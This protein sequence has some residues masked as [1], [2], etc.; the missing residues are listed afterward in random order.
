MLSG[1]ATVRVARGVQSPPLT[2]SQNSRTVHQAGT[3]GI[4]VI[5]WMRQAMIENRAIQGR[6][7]SEMV[8]PTL[9]NLAATRRESCGKSQ[10]ANAM[11]TTQHIPA[12][13][14]SAPLHIG[15]RIRHFSVWFL[16]RRKIRRWAR[17]TSLHSS[18]ISTTPD[19]AVFALSQDNRLGRVTM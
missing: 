8:E 7:R 9:F 18:S 15:Q 5:Q 11:Q 17:S 10:P 14:Q 2:I 16:S 19:Y 12:Y 13:P 1:S 6:R 4:Q 3:R